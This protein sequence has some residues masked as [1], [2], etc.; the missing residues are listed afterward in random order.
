MIG[1]EFVKDKDSR[2]P[3]EGLHDRIIEKAYQ[4][5]LILLGCGKNTIRIAPPLLVNRNQVDKA[6]EILEESITEVEKEFLAIAA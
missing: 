2:Q 5:G 4:R 1:V 3:A 6:V